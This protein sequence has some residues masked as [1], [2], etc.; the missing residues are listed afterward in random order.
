MGAFTSDG[1]T[2]GL[3]AGD[4]G[5]ACCGD[6]GATDEVIDVAMGD[7]AATEDATDDVDALPCCS[8]SLCCSPLTAAAKTA[9]SS[10]RTT[11]AS[12]GTESIGAHEKPP[13]D[14]ID[15]DDEAGN[16]NLLLSLQN[17]PATT[18]AA[19][20]N[21]VVAE[22]DFATS[23]VGDEDIFGVVVGLGAGVVTSQE[24]GCRCGVLDVVG[25]V[26]AVVEDAG[27]TVVL[28]LTTL[29][30]GVMRVL[31]ADREVLWQYIRRE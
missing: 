29:F 28:L 27:G 26:G 5:S 25:V 1:E 3:S 22:G 9:D 24:T 14:T 10:P 11:S 23:L 2:L 30:D 19:V 15:F 7:A 20:A 13:P 16:D 21:T 31:L 8:G 6:D 18:V 17:G 4:S 12:P